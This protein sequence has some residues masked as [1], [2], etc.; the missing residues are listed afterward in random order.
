MNFPKANVWC[1]MLNKKI[2]DRC[3]FE[4]ETVSRQSYLQLLNNCFYPIMQK[5]FNDK[6]ILQEDGTLPHFSKEVRIWLNE[7]LNGK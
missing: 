6:L 3:C 4:D 7:N 2:I 1:V 5:R